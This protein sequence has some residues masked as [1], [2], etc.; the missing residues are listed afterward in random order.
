MSAYHLKMA[1]KLKRDGEALGREGMSKRVIAAVAEFQ[2]NGS[3]YMGAIHLAGRLKAI[4]AM[5]A[6]DGYWREKM[7]DGFQKEAR[8]LATPTPPPEAP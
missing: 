7:D 8:T 6:A 2:A 1:A 5:T 4:A 3:T